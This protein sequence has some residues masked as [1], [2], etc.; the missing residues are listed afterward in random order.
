MGVL[1]CASAQAQ[2][3]AKAV[4]TVINGFVVSVTVTDR[5]AVY[6]DAPLVTIAGGA[7]RG[8]V[9]VATVVNG[10][11]DNVIVRSTGENY[12]ADATALIGP[13]SSPKPLFS[14]K[15]N[16]DNP[17]IINSHPASDRFGTRDGSSP[18]DGNPQEGMRTKSSQLPMG[19]GTTLIRPEMPMN[20]LVIAATCLVSIWGFSNREI[21]EK[22][23]FRPENILARKEYY[24]LVTSAFLHSGWPHL[25]FNMYSLHGFGPAIERE[26]GMLHFLLIYFGSIIGGSLLSLYLHR[27]HE[28]AAYGASGGVCGIIFASVLCHPEGSTHMFPLPVALPSWLFAI[29]FIV[30]SFFAMKA[31][32]DDI[33]HD[34]HLGGAIIGLLITAALHPE[35]ARINWMLLV[36]LLIISGGMLAYLLVNPLFLPLWAFFSPPAWLQK[37]RIPKRQ[38]TKTRPHPVQAIRRLPKL[39]VPLPEPDWLMLK[40]EDE[41]GKLEKDKKGGHDWIDRFGR[42]YDVLVAKAH[43]FTLER[44]TAEVLGRLNTPGLDFVI[45]DTRQLQESQVALLRPFFAKLPDSQFKRVVRSYALKLRNRQ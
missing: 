18:F 28:Y 32:K 16:G 42:S 2:R 27:N 44:F 5:G 23:I 33:G 9:A 15:G 36:A 6:S 24:R 35:I 20:L 3:T 26:F 30:G 12:T 10:A 1:I 45:V 31:Q 11:V 29:V 39:E 4:P 38:G 7:G 40:I 21:E 43:D 14:A 13:P 19:T 34:A 25:V 8:A 37:I 22:L 17:Y 41:V